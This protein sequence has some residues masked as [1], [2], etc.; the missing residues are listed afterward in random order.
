MQDKLCIKLFFIYLIGLLAKDKEILFHMY[1]ILE[2][3]KVT[4]SARCGDATDLQRKRLVENVFGKY[5]KFQ[6]IVGNACQK[7]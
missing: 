3:I 1:F 4:R 2:M 6:E 5:G 7:I